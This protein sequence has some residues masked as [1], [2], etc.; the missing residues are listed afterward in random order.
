MQRACP[1]SSFFR[2]MWRDGGRG[3]EENAA[4]GAAG[5]GREGGVRGGVTAPGSILVMDIG[6]GTRRPGP[7][8]AGGGR[9]AGRGSWERWRR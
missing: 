2:V 5:G 9:K 1:I 4:E 6:A 7:R 8:S 3:D